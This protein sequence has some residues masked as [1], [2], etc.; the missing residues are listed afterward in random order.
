MERETKG[1][2]EMKLFLMI[3]YVLLILKVAYNVL[4]YI[5][6]W[7]NLPYASNQLT[8][9]PLVSVLVPMRNEEKAI[10]LSFLR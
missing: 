5:F 2:K 7:K 4:R 10:I 6:D 1:Y 3:C 8:Q 9:E